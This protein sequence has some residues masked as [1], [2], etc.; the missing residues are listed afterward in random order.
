[1]ENN[2]LKKHPVFLI[3]LVVGILA[4]ASLA[5]CFVLGLNGLLQGSS[6]WLIMGVSALILLI[7]I[8]ILAVYG[9]SHAVKR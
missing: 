6:V 3:T 2:N 7:A 4:L 5:I 8:I 9:L 1:M